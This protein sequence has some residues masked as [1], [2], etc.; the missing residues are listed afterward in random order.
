MSEAERSQDPRL[1][2]IRSLRERGEL[3][4]LLALYG[5]IDQEGEAGWN[6]LELVQEIAKAYSLVGNPAKVEQY[7]LRCAELH[8]RRAALYHG[9]IGWFFQRKKRWARALAWYDRA[10]KTFPTYHLCL[11]RKGYCLER[12]HRPRAAV[13][14]LEAAAASFAAA[15]AAQQERSRGIEAQVLFH[16]ARNLREIGR[17]AEARAALDRCAEIDARPDVV[18]KPEH[19]LA[20]YAATH[21]RDGDPQAAIRCLDEARERDPR[22]A[23]IWER[24]G[25]AYAA[26]GRTEDAERAL[27]HATGLPKGAVALV[28]LARLYLDQERSTDAA[29]T[30]AAALQHHPQGEVQIWMEIAELH[31]RLGRPAAALEILGRLSAGRVPPQSTLAVSIEQRIAACAAE[32]GRLD[33]AIVHLRAALAH[34]PEDL[35]LRR[36]LEQL[37][38]AAESPAAA[39]Q[40]RLEIV[41]RPLPDEIARLLAVP[42]VRE[43]GQLAAYYPGRGF[44]FIASPGREQPVFFH[45]SHVDRQDATDLRVGT[46]VSF[47]VAVNPRNG[48]TQA[49]DVRICTDEANAA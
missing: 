42:R 13:A 33:E 9:Q 44:G 10:L 38:S 26:A 40:R 37:E 41:D 43:R 49:E 16:L 15:P 27:V 19:R 2:E 32:H 48:K 7:F 39:C 46:Q 5:S 21:L 31:R 14:A 29:Q 6:D 18:I 23:V 20:S 3:R 28:T 4:R 47:V 35:D 22:S 36:R 17:T 11:F 34:D 1:Q 24:L 30:L 12:L 45:V 25:L 8:P